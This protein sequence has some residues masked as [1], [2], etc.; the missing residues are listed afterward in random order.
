MKIAIH[1]GEV[2]CAEVGP[3]YESLRQ[4][5]RFKWSRSDK[6]M[7]GDD[8]LITLDA[9]AACCKLPANV[10]AR[11]DHLQKI[12][13]AIERQRATEKPI[14]LVEFPIKNA[15]LMSHQIAGANM[16]LLQ[17]GAIDPEKLR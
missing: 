2:I 3:Y 16:A 14:P 1:E 5:G 12:A 8:C 4:T 10:A 6:T 17:F 11:R 13:D 15:E 9:L 7:R